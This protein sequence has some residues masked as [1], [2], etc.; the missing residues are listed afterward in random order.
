MTEF[1]LS[2][3][4]Y[5]DVHKK[6]LLNGPDGARW[7]QL[8][9]GGLATS[10]HELLVHAMFQEQQD[11]DGFRTYEE[12]AA[13]AQ[14]RERQFRDYFELS[15]TGVRARTS[16]SDVPKGQTERL[17]VAVALMTAN[18]AAGLTTADW[19]RIEE[20]RAQKTLDHE[21]RWRA[22]T[23]ER[24]VRVEAK[25]TVS[26]ERSHIKTATVS[27]M[28]GHIAEK[29]KDARSGSPG[30]PSVEYG[31]ITAVSSADGPPTVFALD[32]PSPDEQEEPRRE[33]V[34]A[35][36][37]FYA[38]FLRLVSRFRMLSALQNRLRA[39]EA[40]SDLD[41]L[42]GLA[43][44]DEDG[45]P[46]SV[47]TA[48]GYRRLLIDGVIGRVLVAPSRRWNRDTPRLDHAQF[49]GVETRVFEVVAKQNFGHLLAYRAKR[50]RHSELVS[51]ALPHGQGPLQGRLD[52]AVTDA[53]IAFGRF[54]SD[55]LDGG[56]L[57]E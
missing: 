45:D 51:V 37:G 49:V 15:A 38:S 23:G 8:F 14:S 33:R 7:K 55:D 6:V 22:S 18:R 11:R 53:G 27:R 34:L 9:E 31:V 24:F 30:T 4:P 21:H 48:L 56:A 26:P 52:F 29:K 50:R 2:V 19:R 25:G 46:V 42:D 28:K 43:L 57:R 5:D 17:G 41:D 10:D 3:Q 47:P 16:A 39:L 40:V 20:S 44:V 13:L 1:T 54:E 36:L 35:R 12:L 32:P